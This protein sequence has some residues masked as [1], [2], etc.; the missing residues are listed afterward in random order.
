MEI[1][2]RASLVGQR[3]K[4]TQRDQAENEFGAHSCC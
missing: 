3:R 1:L 2:R 4:H